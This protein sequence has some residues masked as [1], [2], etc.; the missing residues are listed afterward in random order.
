[1]RIHTEEQFFRVI[2]DLLDQLEEMDYQE[3][4]VKVLTVL[5]LYIKDN[6]YSIYDIIIFLTNTV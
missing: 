6:P 3:E 4:E 1:M 5:L 2:M